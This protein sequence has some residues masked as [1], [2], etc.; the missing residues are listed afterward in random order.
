MFHV[1]QGVPVMI[2]RVL[3]LSSVAVFALSA[4]SAY[5]EDTTPVSRTEFLKAVGELKEQIQSLKVPAPPAAPG[6]VSTTGGTA[7]SAVASTSQTEAELTN[8]I[9][10][11][12]KQVAKLQQAKDELTNI[13]DNHSIMLHDIASDRETPGG[14]KHFVPNVQAIRDD[15]DARRA[16]VDTVVHDMV[17]N[18]G[19]LRIR[20]DMSTGQS[21]VINGLSTVYVPPH[22]V[23][24]VTVPSGTA[25]TELAGEAPKSWM[26][27]APNYSQEVIIAPAVRNTVASGQWQYNPIT[28]VWWRTLQ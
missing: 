18:S 11:L 28:N 4:L 7:S 6:T 13:A 23:Q 20:N 2:R 5:G 19:E 3:S 25:T 9:A 26:I 16:L 24:V 10:A 1:F 27:G 15:H 12:E 14:G 8:R 22:T 17:R 21:L